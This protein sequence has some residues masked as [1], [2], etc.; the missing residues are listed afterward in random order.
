MMFDFRGT[1]IIFRDVEK[2]WLLLCLAP[3]W[4]LALWEAHKRSSAFREPSVKLH[5]PTTKLPSRQGRIA[6]WCF[7][8]IGFSL[9]VAVLAKPE[10]KLTYWDT[11]Y[12]KL[13][14][15][16]LFD[17][18]LSMKY[19]EDL[20][21][22]R[23][24]AAKSVV[25]EF[26]GMLW[27]DIDLNGNYSLALIPFAGAAQPFFAPF[28]TSREEVLSNLAHLD[29]K[30][31]TRKGTSLWAALRAYDTLLLRY[32]PDKEALD[33]G[34]LISDGG[35]EEGRGGEEDVLLQLI[36]ELRDPYR[37][38]VLNNGEPVVTRSS[39]IS[40][41]VV[42]YSVGIGKI[43][44]AS[45]GSRVPAPVEL[46]K[47]DAAG[48]FIDYYRENET[49][50]S[51]RPLRSTLDEDILRRVSREGGGEYF[52][53][54]DRAELLFRLKETILKQRREVAKVPRYQ[55]EP[56]RNWLIA[57]AFFIFYFL[58]GYGRW[59][60]WLFRHSISRFRK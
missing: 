45:D 58:F 36:Q 33:I 20:K 2:L 49:N 8:S 28:T 37:M 25:R 5:I 23:L 42:L 44:I 43:N 53:F 51:S 26:I 21:P 15:T 13:R 47:R 54:L 39:E 7:L 12:G 27:T 38:Q 22:N 46:V 4:V 17:D 19:A 50:P 34:I 6:W 30:V 9:L 29:E 35:K 16:V 32:P 3:L 56:V 52:P 11:V 18:S 10:A 59:L 1:E 40:R 60:V 14:I 41:R 48:N 57:P 31:I 24:S 55:Y